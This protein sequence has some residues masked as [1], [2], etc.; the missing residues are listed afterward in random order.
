MANDVI[1]WVLEEAD[2]AM[3]L[4]RMTPAYEQVIAHHVTLKADPG[5]QESA[6][7]AQDAEI[8]GLADDGAGVQAAV[9]RLNGTTRRPDGGV[10]HITWSL[11]AGR[12]AVESNGVIA[13]CG[14]VARAPIKIQLCA[15]RF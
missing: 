12:R 6:P 7:G 5:A 9:V 15:S 3:L 11:A 2:R 14:W 13:K 10:Y 8:I 1:G 4:D